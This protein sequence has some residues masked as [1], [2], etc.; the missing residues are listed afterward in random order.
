VEELVPA[1]RKTSKL[2]DADRKA[3]EGFLRTRRV[4]GTLDWTGLLGRNDSPSQR[5]ADLESAVNTAV[6]R[7]LKK[8]HFDTL[9]GCWDWTGATALKG[10]SRFAFC[11]KYGKR[12]ST[13]GHRFS[14]LYFRGAI[15][16][17]FYLDHL[18]GIRD[19]VNPFH[20][21]AV[22]LRENSLR[23]ARW[24]RRKVRQPRC[25]HGHKFPECYPWPKKYRTCLTCRQRRLNSLRSQVKEL[26]RKTHR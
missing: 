22:T 11:D 23:Q 20:L 16:D 26:E 7:F 17:G 1:K 8:V 3:I 4:T 2:S 9:T 6:G 21:E 15:P 10:Y 5:A 19:C 18:C 14:Y 13:S 25:V 24:A 12:I